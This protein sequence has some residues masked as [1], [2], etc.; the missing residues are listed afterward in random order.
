MSLLIEAT[1]ERQILLWKMANSA[2]FDLTTSVCSIS[3]KEC[4]CT[5]HFYFLH[6]TGYMLAHQSLILY[7]V[8]QI[9]TVRELYSVAVHKILILSDPDLLVGSCF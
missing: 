8:G 6:C 9:L 2:T 3:R 7:H 1:C 5:G 4:P